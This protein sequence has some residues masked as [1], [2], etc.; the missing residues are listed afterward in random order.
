MSNWTDK[1]ILIVEDVETNLMFFRAALARSG[2]TVIWAKDGVDAIRKVQEDQNI[3]LI[4]M[5]LRMP[6]MDGFIATETIKS[7]RPDIPVIAQTTYTD[8]FDIKRIYESGC[9]DYL[10]KPIRLHDLLEK[11]GQ[12]LNKLTP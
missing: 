2:A 7:I 11:L 8:E 10:A 1:K 6:N 9:D 5:D 4:L 12:Y 3:D